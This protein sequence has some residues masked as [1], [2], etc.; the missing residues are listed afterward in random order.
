MGFELG[1][2]SSLNELSTSVASMNMGEM[3]S[4]AAVNRRV[5][6]SSLTCGANLYNNLAAV[7]WTAV[8]LFPLIK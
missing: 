5:V 7:H 3:V 8:L 2:S 4:G 6:S 1:I